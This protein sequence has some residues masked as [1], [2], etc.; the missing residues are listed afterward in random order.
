VCYTRIK[1]SKLKLIIILYCLCVTYIAHR[2]RDRKT[3]YTATLRIFLGRF[4]RKKFKNHVIITSFFQKIAIPKLHSRAIIKLKAFLNN[5]FW[6]KN[7]FKILTRWRHKQ[8]HALLALRLC[9]IHQIKGMF[10]AN[11]VWYSN[12]SFYCC[13]TS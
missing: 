11:S 8:K 5:F 10:K 13:M 6:W 3:K 1:T 2:L 12:L 9:T 7:I 4:L